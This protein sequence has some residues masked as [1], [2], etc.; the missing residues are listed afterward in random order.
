MSTKSFIASGADTHTHTH[1]HTRT[2]ACVQIKEIQA[3][4][5][6]CSWQ[7]AQMDGIGQSKGQKMPQTK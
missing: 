2:Q 1:T 5:P 7:E 3:Y 4:Q 6:S